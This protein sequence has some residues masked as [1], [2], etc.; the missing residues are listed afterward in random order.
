MPQLKTILFTVLLAAGA[1]AQGEDCPNRATVCPDNCRGSQCP[2]FLNSECRVNP[3]HGLCAPNFFRATNGR[4]VT[5]RCDV[6]RCGEKDCPGNRVCVEEIVPPSCP[7]NGTQC[8]QFIRSRCVLPPLPTDCSQITCGPGMYCRERRGE[9]V[10]C[11]RARNCNQLTCG[12]GLSCSVT[13]E[14]PVCMEP[15]KPTTSSPMP[16]ISTPFPNFCDFCASLGEVCSVVNGSYQ[17]IVPS[18][19]NSIRIN[20]CLGLGQICKEIN[21]TATCEFANSC[22]EISCPRGTVCV[23]FGIAICNPITVAE[24]CDQLNCEVIPGMVCEQ[25]NDSAVCVVGC[26]AN[27]VEI[28]ANIQA[29]CAVVNGTPDCVIDTQQSCDEIVCTEGGTCVHVS[30]PSR[31]FSLALCVPSQF[32]G[33]IPN[34]ESFMCPGSPTPLCRETDICTNTY[35]NGLFVGPSCN[36]FTTNCIDDLSCALNEV[37]TDVPNDLEAAVTF[38]TVCLPTMLVFEF[39]DS[40]TSGTKEC[41]DDLVCQDIALGGANIGTACGNLVPNPIAAS[42]AQLMPCPAPGTECVGYFVAGTGPVA[43]CVD[44]GSADGI[45]EIFS[46]L[47]NQ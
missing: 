8:R 3:C 7:G 44:K 12:E 30:L 6:E 1:L 25:R 40:C 19:C 34:I 31:N 47:G 4:N 21:G 16:P 33:S 37:C 13:E 22:S 41:P 43:Q 23:E 11:A 27:L 35:Q 15:E 38:S 9:G 18:E 14:G 39:G 10:K 36:N 46:T 26:S 24:T 42:C 20:Y 29:R 45:F 2:R 5:D 28:C 17:C 32:I